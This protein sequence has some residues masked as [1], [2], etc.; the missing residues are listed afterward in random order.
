MVRCSCLV[1]FS[2][3]KSSVFRHALASHLQNVYCLN[4]SEDPFWKND[5][6]G[7]FKLWNNPSLAKE[8]FTKVAMACCSHLVIFFL[9]GKVLCF[10]MRWQVAC[11]MF[12]VWRLLW[13]IPKTLWKNDISH[14]TC[15]CIWHKPFIQMVK[16]S[17]FLW[18]AAHILLFLIFFKEKL[19]VS[20]HV[21][22]LLAWTLV[23]FASKK[24]Y[25]SVVF[26]PWRW[27]CWSVYPR[28]YLTKKQ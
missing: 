3:R 23:H 24:C 20:A 5:I 15:T 14:Y 13:S 7:S 17:K 1:I 6:S 2:A 25:L 19:G 18:C 27:N 21:S 4:R 28:F 10:S 16:Y 12:T 8:L 11:E 22:K 9:Q 26:A